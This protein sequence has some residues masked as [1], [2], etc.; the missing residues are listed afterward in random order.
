MSENI[1]E[2]N[3]LAKSFGNQWA[4][5]NINV[6]VKKGITTGLVGPNGAGKTTLFS[7]FCGFLKPTKKGATSSVTPFLICN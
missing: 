3:G 6:N 4:L 5:Y 2:T 7:L 1:I